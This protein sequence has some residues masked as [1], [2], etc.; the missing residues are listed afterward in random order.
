ML[1]LQMAAYW[2]EGNTREV[3]VPAEKKKLEDLVEKRKVEVVS[4]PAAIAPEKKAAI[5]SSSSASPRPNSPLSGRKYVRKL[6]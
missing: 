6:D 3:S 5:S 1:A 2:K 4:S